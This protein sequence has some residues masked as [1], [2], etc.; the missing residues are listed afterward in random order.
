MQISLLFF[1]VL[2]LC[3]FLCLPQHICRDG[4]PG[5]SRC[6]GN[7]PI[8]TDTRALG[9]E[10]DTRDGRSYCCAAYCDDAVPTRVALGTQN[11]RCRNGICPS[12]PSQICRTMSDGNEYCCPLPAG[13]TPAG[14]G[15]G[16]ANDSSCADVA[17]DCA[18]RADLC[19]IEFAYDQMVRDCPKTCNVC[20]GVCED[21]GTECPD[22]Q[23][24]GYC[25]RALYNDLMNWQ[26]PRSCNRCANRR[27]PR[28][29]L[30]T[31]RKRRQI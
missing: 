18:Q 22:R 9:C 27:R 19:I 29:R 25:G 4:Q 26:C 17:R 20:P 5:L 15:G 1:G 3:F 10:L 16:S 24:A 6:Q 31:G 30:Y 14:G 21:L 12:D 7:P 23:R 13:P 8:C 28:G 11:G 2:F